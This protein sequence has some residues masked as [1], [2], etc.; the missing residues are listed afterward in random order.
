MTGVA[1]GTAVIS[2]TTGAGCVA[3]STVTVISAPPAISGTL[4]VC[5]G[6]TTT[7]TD[8]GGG[9]WTSSA[10]SIATIGSASGIVS[11]LTAGTTNITYSLGA[12]CQVGAVFTV[13]A[14]P[15]AIGGTPTVCEGAITNLTD[16]TTGGTWSTTSANASV[17][18]TGTTGAVTGITAGTALISYTTA[19]SCTAT[20][21]VTVNA[22]PSAITGSLGIC[23]GGTGTLSSTPAGGSW[24]SGA[25]GTVSINPTTGVIAGV[26]IGTAPIT[27]TLPVTGCKAATTVTVNP[28]PATITGTMTVCV[29]STTTLSDAT[30]GG[31]WTSG[32]P[33]IATIGSSSGGV[34]GI[35]AGTALITYTAAITGCT[36]SATV[37]VNPLPSVAAIGGTPV[38]CTGNT[39]LLTD[40]T[41]GGVWSTGGAGMATIG[42]TGLVTGVTAGTENVTYTVTTSFGCVGAVSTTVTVNTSPAS[43]TGTLA[44]CA[45]QATTLSDVSAGGTWSS[46]SGSIALVG[47][48]SGIVSGSGAGT[49]TIS[50]TVSNGCSATAVVTVN[51]LPSPITGVTHVCVGAA[52]TLTDAG[53]GSW[54]SSNTS[55]AS[56]GSSSGIVIGVAPGVDTITYTLPTGCTTSTGVTVNPL[57]VA[58]T[59]TGTSSVCAGSTITL[60]DAI[61]GGVWSTTNASVAI[62]G[63]TGIVTGVAGGTDTIKYSVTNIC[64]TAVASYAITVNPLAV[65]GTIS[66]SSLVCV[67]TPVTLTDA[68]AGGTWSSSNTA[69]A[70]V[71]TGSGVVNGVAVGT[72]TI[73]YTVSNVCNTATALYAIT[74]SALPSAGTITGIDSVCPGDSVTLSSSATGG[75]WSASNS[76]ATVTATGKVHGVSTG[77]VMISYIV[78]NSCGTATALFAMT[79]RSLTI[80]RV[81]VQ[82]EPVVATGIKVYPN[83]SPGMFTVEFPP[84]IGT[85]QI[86]ITDVLGKTL[87]TQ[88]VDGNAQKAIFRLNAAPGSYMVKVEAGGQ[89]W[90]SKVVIW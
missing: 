44:V 18:G 22:A 80:C 2:Y 84:V 60:S 1:P 32:S 29:G 52:T 10:P 61:S 76:N 73:T 47:S 58:G 86:S 90:H 39:R 35:V 30:P 56:V 71:G 19:G 20:K 41:L 26:A 78:T 57:P 74:V 48:A 87:E 53:G 11:G 27:Y 12:A 31:T 49:A 72:A 67:G 75:S 13:N 17:S 38:V 46:S 42:S 63:S 54:T 45:G 5:V 62:V 88:A 70:T 14:N 77:T 4:H 66:G 68:A 24:V 81:G 33:G 16:V 23:L 51:P 40:G 9:T 3:T 15:A 36:R 89:T 82:P 37:T 34:N 50:Y 83:P 21:T 7:L 28:L 64:G 55:I 69:I 79:V 6:G 8:P 85:A 59:I 25:S 65:A 43:I